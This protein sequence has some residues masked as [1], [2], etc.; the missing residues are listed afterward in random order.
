MHGYEGGTEAW[1]NYDHELHAR[2]HA[3]Q[4]ENPRGIPKSIES[5]MMSACGELL[6]QRSILVNGV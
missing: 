2:L 6:C 1:S 3:D 4:C 5:T